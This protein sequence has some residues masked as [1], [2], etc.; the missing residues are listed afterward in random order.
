MR[1]CPKCYKK[2]ENDKQVCP[3]DLCPLVAVEAGPLDLM[4]GKLI[5]NHFLLVE[6]IG[7]GGMG[8]VFK[9]IHTE[10]G[11][12]CAI[13]FLTSVGANDEAALA[14]FRRE[15][16]MA[17]R[18]DNPHVVII[19]DFGQMEGGTAYLAMEY[20]EGAPLSKF[21]ARERPVSIERVVRIA[22]QIGAALEAAHR[23]GIVHRDLKPD[24]IMI[25]QKGGQAD[26]VKVHD[27]RI[28]KTDA[29]DSADVITQGNIVLGTPVYMSPEQLAGGKLDGRSDV[30]SFALIVYEILGG[31]LQF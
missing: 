26:F 8:S 25:T 27:F 7:R 21:V 14:R 2:Y 13:K 23:L 1:A 29:D 12:I 31:R 17:S 5:A 16:Q 20:V 3:D 9:A 30:Y 6:E 19:Y 11:R 24:N 15:A 10:M 22:G 18:I 28:A 4:P